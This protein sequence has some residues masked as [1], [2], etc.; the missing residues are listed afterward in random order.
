M[1]S[2]ALLPRT[3]AETGPCKPDSFNG[4]VCGDGPG[5]ARVIDGTTSPSRHFAFAWRS[6]SSAPLDLAT[7]AE[8][9]DLRNALIRLSDGAL[10][11]ETEG[12]FWSTGGPHVNRYEQTAAWSPNSRFAVEILDY[13]WQTLELRLFAI[14]ADDKILVLDLKPVIEPAV[15]KTLARVVKDAGAFDF[16]IFGSNDSEIPHLAIDSQGLIKARV[17]MEKAKPETVTVLFDV[18]L[19][20]TV[21]NGTLGVRE[22][23]VRRRRER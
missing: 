18:T 17:Q 19:R 15:R 8:H 1:F 10:L 4:L 16:A 20:A 9:Y 6:M 22:V 7:D 11:W 14:G 2:F 23:S 5:A 21:R 13:R 3:Q 12:S